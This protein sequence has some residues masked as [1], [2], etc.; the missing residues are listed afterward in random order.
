[1]PGSAAN[2]DW[3]GKLPNTL[4]ISGL[5]RQPGPNKKRLRRPRSTFGAVPGRSADSRASDREIRDRRSGI[6]TDGAPAFADRIDGGG[7]VEIRGGLL[8]CQSHGMEI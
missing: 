3:T 2:A 1:M 8:C 6:D 4:G 7:V 5:L